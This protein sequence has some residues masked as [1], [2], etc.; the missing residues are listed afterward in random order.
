MV[1]DQL[2]IQRRVS[3]LGKPG[4]RRE[5]D[6]IPL[7]SRSGPGREISF[8][9]RASITFH[10]EFS[11]ADSGN[12]G[13]RRLEHLRREKKLSRQ[14]EPRFVGD[15]SCENYS[16]TYTPV[17]LAVSNMIFQNP[18][19][20]RCII[21]FARANEMYSILLAVLVIILLRRLRYGRRCRL[22]DRDYGFPSTVTYCR[23]ELFPS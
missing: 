8:L 6:L 21:V 7:A 19:F 13:T 1:R 17:R 4:G 18:R 23:D 20:P 14:L 10:G 15:A 16:A 9:E 12:R 2:P 22:P 11:L 5:C 3:S